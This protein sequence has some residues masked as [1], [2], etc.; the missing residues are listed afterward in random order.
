MVCVCRVP[1][2]SE[3]NWNEISLAH[4]GKSV[5]VPE[6]IA[7]IDEM[8]NLPKAEHG[9]DD[10]DKA[11]CSNSFDQSEDELRVL[12]RHLWP[13]IKDWHKDAI[14][15]YPSDQPSCNNAHIDA[16]RKSSSE[17]DASVTK[18]T[19]IRQKKH[20]EFVVSNADV[21]VLIKLAVNRL[22]VLCAPRSHEAAPKAELN[23]ANMEGGT[24]AATHT[25]ATDGG[26]LMKLK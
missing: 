10:C 21:T 3:L 7:M 25:G 17:L 2:N 4:S 6:V 15:D 18:G 26:A 11:H 16:V 20:A 9:E 19:E 22:N 14:K 1:S 13:V 8:L 12:T 23:S 24:T 5:D